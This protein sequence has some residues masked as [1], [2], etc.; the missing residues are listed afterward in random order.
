MRQEDCTSMRL[1]ESST[2]TGTAI[3]LSLTVVLNPGS[4]DP[5]LQRTI[6]II[7]LLHYY[8]YIYIACIIKIYCIYN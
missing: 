2:S 6:A 7:M 1:Q 3:R 4:R 8:I 5:H